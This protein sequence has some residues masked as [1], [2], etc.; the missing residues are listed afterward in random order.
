[1]AAEEV[2]DVYEVYDVERVMEHGPGIYAGTDLDVR[3]VVARMPREVK[4]R[5]HLDR[6][7]WHRFPHAYGVDD[8]VPRDLSAL[9]SA[10]GAQADQVL[11]SL[12]STV[13]HQGGTSPSGAL[14]VPFLLRAAADPSAHGRA[15]ALRLVAELARPEHYGDG[16]R[17]G[18]LRSTETRGLWDN[19]GYPVSWSVEAAQD[20]VAADAAILLALLDCS[21]PDIRAL[22]CY[23]LAPASGEVGRISAAL[24]DRFRAE[25]DPS[26]R[27][28][29]VLAIGQLALE[30]GDGQAVAWTRGL[31]SAPERPD[32]VRVS[33]ALAWSC[34]VD[35]PVPEELRTVLDDIVTDDLVRLMAAV[36]WMRVV[37]DHGAG[38]TR[39][40]ARMLGPDARPAAA[41]DPFA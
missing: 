40:V 8:S 19:N 39:C 36:P 33:A 21:V 28:S 11:G 25:E 12:W 9:R 27:A 2:Y 26:V 35:V 15:G 29:L 14:A 23:A 13:C 4:E 41:A 1:M 30:R 32:E 24:H 16:T 5:F 10:D 31:W 6:V 37:D 22:A 3:A 38:L 17:T 7:P 20:A 18:L 34:L